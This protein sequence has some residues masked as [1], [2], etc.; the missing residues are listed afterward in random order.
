[1]TRPLSLLVLAILSGGAVGVG[2]AQPPAFRAGAAVADVTPPLGTS[3]NGGMRDQRATV[4][5][6]PLHARCLVLDDGRSR[7]AFA[8]VD[9]CM[10]PREVTEEARRRVQAECG[11]PGDRLLISA[12][13]SHSTG[14]CTGVFQSEPDLSYPAQV[15]RGIV[16]GVRR[17][18]ARLAPARV[19]W[20]S[21]QAP[22]DVFNR[23]FHMKPGSVAQN[24]FGGVDQVQMNPGV[25]NPNVLRPAGPVD[26]EVAVVSVVG[27]DG[28]PLALLANYGLHYVG[29]V[30]PGHVSADYFGAFARRVGE[31]LEAGPEFVGIMTN[32]ASG[33]VNN[34]DVRG[35]AVR[36][37]PYEQIRLVAD[38]VA[39]EAARVQRSLTHRDWIPLAGAAADLELGVRKPGPADLERARGLLAAAPGPEFTA[40]PQIY[41]REALLLAAYPDRV[42]ARLQALR[43]GDLTVTA[44][45]C[46]VFAEIG[47][48]LK[49]RARGRPTFT[50]SLA[51]GYNG[52]LPTPAHHALGGYETWRARSS[53]LE[54]Q[55]SPRIV[56]RLLELAADLR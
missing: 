45:P 52:Y 36:R 9:S 13:H 23:R 43:L 48:E 30:G 54:A 47:L 42:P 14:T 12:T 8:V 33:D 35:P 19:G 49:Q 18:V 31:L 37:E 38:R 11:I 28:K 5:H 29:G 4:I 3:L 21:G 26:P 56:N 7:L 41:A 20:G 51:N 25:G 46:E 6:D 22:E 1:M 32:G 10:L 53:Y 39:R 15:T 34:V 44:I 17:A 27:V 24:P 55:A 40:M 2:R 16:E 50:V